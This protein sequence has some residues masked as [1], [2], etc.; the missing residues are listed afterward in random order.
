MMV[1]NQPTTPKDGITKSAKIAVFFVGFF[2]FLQ[3]YSIQAILPILAKEL[4]ATAVQIGIL[5]GM[6]VSAIALSSPFTGM[7]SDSIGRKK[8]I[9]T[10]FFALSIPTALASL[11]HN[12]HEL[13]LWRFVQ[14]LT[15]PSMTV[16]L[17]AYIAEEFPKHIAKITA[18]YVSGTVLGGFLGRFILGY[19]HNFIGWRH[20]FFVMAFITLTGAFMII[21]LLP[22]S[23]NFHKNQNIQS[24]WR[25]LKL[26][27]HNQDVLLA[28]ALGACILFSLVGC[29]TFINLHLA[30]APYHLSS[31][32]LAN[33]F[34]VYLI[35]MVITPLST[36]LMM[37]FGIYKTIIVTIILSLLGLVMTLN[38]PLP[39][40][41]VGLTL[42]CTGVF[43]SQTA[44]ISHI[45]TKVSI[46]RSLASG[47]Y[48]MSYYAGG[49][50]GA[51]ACGFAYTYGSWL[52]VVFIIIIVQLLGMG[53]VLRLMKR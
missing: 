21:Y 16:V 19:L 12:I 22:N 38:K 46:G 50:L 26:H 1:I 8:M 11:S 39:I 42:M 49:S 31:V 52:G 25:I 37:R 23:V 17:I 30:H 3:V 2:A 51:L 34:L 28:C 9:V 32:A 7:I 40:I 20:A 41:I 15:I 10:A 47:L 29:F 5:V 53:V 33:I 36:R 18:Y 14:G 45:G 4:S 35:G 13:S 44:T 6:T 48:Y 43:I 27:C 24:T